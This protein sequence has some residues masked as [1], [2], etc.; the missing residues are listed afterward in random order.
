MPRPNEEKQSELSRVDEE[1]K[2]DDEVAESAGQVLARA[3]P[4][5]EG[6][7]VYLGMAQAEMDAAYESPDID[8][9][10]H[11]RIEDPLG[12]VRD[13]A[14]HDAI[15]RRLRAIED[16]LQRNNAGGPDEAERK[17]EN[18]R[19]FLLFFGLAS[20]A[21]S[22]ATLILTA[23]HRCAAGRSDDDLPLPDAVKAR[24][25]ELVD[26]WKGMS[27][28]DFWAQ[29]GKY[30][31][32]SDATFADLIFFMQY[33]K[34]LAPLQAPFY[35][36]SYTDQDAFVARLVQADRTQDIAALFN[37]LPTFEYRQ[38]GRPSPEKL[39]RFICADLAQMAL[40]ELAR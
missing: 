12:G 10:Q 34:Q 22:V 35:W 32:V 11:F 13:N 2:Y 3:A 18:V 39:P 16:V 25:R 26:A 38:D 24:I 19:K 21:L 8:A 20:I 37:L 31:K 9:A 5:I 28:A 6:A 15:E 4:N 30:A 40:G 33:T 27:D 1:R 17:K 23:V 14:G 29:I 7:I 36:N